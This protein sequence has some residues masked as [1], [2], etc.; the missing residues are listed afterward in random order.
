MFLQ[1]YEKNT[2]NPVEKLVKDMNSTSQ[3][4]KYI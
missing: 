3:K 2:N 1:I 4:G